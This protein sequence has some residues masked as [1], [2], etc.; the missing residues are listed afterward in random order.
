M[1]RIDSAPWRASTIRTTTSTEFE[2]YVTGRFAA[3]NNLLVAGNLL[4]HAVELLA[5]FQLLRRVPDGRLG[6]EVTRLARKPYRHD[7]HILWSD[8]KADVGRSSLDRF[9]AV[10]ADLNRWEDLRYGGYPM[11]IPTTM[12]FMMRRGPHETWSDEPHEE[13]VLVL[14]DID[15]LFTAMVAASGINPGFLGERHRLKLALREW[16]AKDNLHPMADVFRTDPPPGN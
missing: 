8:F 13:Y 16:Y 2:Y 5:K 3:L 10:V 12:S 7:L 4:H 1:T 14:E 9:D 15:E 11:G 6:Q